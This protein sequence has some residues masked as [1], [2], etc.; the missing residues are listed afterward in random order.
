MWAVYASRKH[1]S[2]LRDRNVEVDIEVQ[3]GPREKNDKYSECGVLIVSCL[4]LE[5]TELHTPP[6]WRIGWGR[7]K[8]QGLPIGGLEVLNCVLAT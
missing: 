4:D 1:K 6:Y 3:D 5:A 7:F 2:N 8:P